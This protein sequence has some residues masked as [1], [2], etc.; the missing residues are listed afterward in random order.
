MKICSTSDLREKEVINLCDGE[1]LG[2][3]TEFELDVCE[4]RI[5][6]LVIPSEIGLFGCPR[7]DDLV[8]PWEKIECIGEDTILVKVTPAELCKC[9]P[10]KKKRNKRLF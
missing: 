8:I 1:R 9:T 5:T 4:A 6:A 7:G 2:Y 10:D 3:V